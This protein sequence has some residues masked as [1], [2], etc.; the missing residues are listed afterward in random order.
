MFTWTTSPMTPI[1]GDA[2]AL[3]N[4]FQNNAAAQGISVSGYLNTSDPASAPSYVASVDFPAPYDPNAIRAQL[5]AMLSQLFYFFG[6]VTDQWYGSAN[7]VGG[8]PSSPGTEGSFLSSVES[9]VSSFVSG[10]E[11]AA[12]KGLSAAA[13]GVKS[14][15]DE[16]NHL[17]NDATVISVSLGLAA[18]AIVAAYFYTLKKVGA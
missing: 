7:G 5:E 1:S 16:V 18:L 12:S 9:G 8:A 11:S 3:I 10:V 15:T 13:S 6:S 4:A 17:A 14:A 2:Q